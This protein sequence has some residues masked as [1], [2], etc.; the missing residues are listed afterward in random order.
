MQHFDLE[1]EDAS[2]ESA[3][4]ASQLEQAIINL[5]TNAREASSAE[6][7]VT[8]SV[9]R[10][11]GGVEINVLDSGKGMSDD[12]LAQAF[13]PFYSTKQRGSGIGLTLVREIVEA[14]HGV[15]NLCNREEGG[16]RVSIWLPK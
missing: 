16:L 9:L 13:I 14:H 4:D 6:D 15:L 8:V 7:P 11:R 10:K 3:F 1:C 2:L 12:V 5:V